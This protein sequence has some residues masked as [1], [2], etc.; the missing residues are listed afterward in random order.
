MPGNEWGMPMK[1]FWDQRYS[2]EGSAYGEMPNE[3]LVTQ[4]ERFRPGMSVLVVGDGEGRN[5]VW[6]AQ[7]GLD[8]TSIDYS[9]A[10]VQKAQVLAAARDVKLNVICA[11]L[12]EWAWPQARFDAV[13][14]IYLHF[15]SVAR[16]QMHAR[17][18]EALVPG[19]VL[20]ME[21]FNKAQL[22]YPSGGPPLEDALF[23][24]EL[25]K[26]DFVAANIEQCEELVVQLN[27]GKYHVGP[28]AVV[29]LIAR[30]SE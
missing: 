24:A 27:E 9:V 16:P 23:S 21:A 6:L 28:A 30:R 4:A 26:Q 7:Q 22:E 14:S 3:F 2:E 19:G 1:E 17:M 15:P 10:G 5:G 18:L 29:R 13:V 12:N 25:L 8:V 11:D 20:V